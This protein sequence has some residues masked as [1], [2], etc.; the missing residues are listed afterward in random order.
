[1]EKNNKKQNVVIILLIVIIL[2]LVGLFTMFYLKN[3]D[4]KTN[5][6][7]KVNESVKEQQGNN[8]KEVISKDKYDEYVK[9]LNK[10]DGLCYDIISSYDYKNNVIPDD[11]YISMAFRTTPETIKIDSSS[12]PKYA[13]EIDGD[14]VEGKRIEDLQKVIDNKFYKKYTIKKSYLSS[15]KYKYLDSSDYTYYYY[16]SSNN[17]LIDIEKLGG[18]YGCAGGPGISRVVFNIEKDGNK[19]EFSVASSQRYSDGTNT[20][21]EDKNNKI[22]T[23][24]FDEKTN[25]YTIEGKVYNSDEEF[26][27]KYKERFEQVKV[28]FIL[29]GTTYKLSHLE[30]IN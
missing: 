28:V 14:Y 8:K 17:A 19:L 22:I 9:I 3:E 24:Y 20:T 16:S 21:L 13:D 25:K 6:K 29:D 4:N 26:V 7:T 5:D 27:E 10:Y 30:K 15:D 12:L 1:M 11:Y 23:T 2:I 18:G